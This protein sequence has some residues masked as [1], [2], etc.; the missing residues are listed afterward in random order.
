M[1]QFRKYCIGML[2]LA[3]LVLVTACGRANNGATTDNNGAAGDNGTVTDG[4]NG[5]G[6]GI[7]TNV[8]DILF[9]TD[10]DGVYDHTDV[11]GDGLLE[12]IG[13][14]SNDV[15][16]DLINDVTGDDTMVDGNVNNNGTVDGTGTVGDGAGTD[17]P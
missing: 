12:E 5:T 4:E 14:D 15:V 16:D 7:G 9:D 11:D 8:D 10:G 6:S 2:L 13:N 17:L 1:K 3:T